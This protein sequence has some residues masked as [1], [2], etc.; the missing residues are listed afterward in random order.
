[1]K[2]AF[3]FLLFL[4]LLGTH[5]TKAQDNEIGI[6]GGVANYKGDLA[7]TIQFNEFRPAAG[8]FYKKN[9][10]RFFSMGAYLTHGSV[11]GSD[12]NV[13]TRR[14]RNLS[15]ESDITELSFIVEFNFLPFVKGR[16]PYRFTPNVFLGVGGFYFNPTTTLDGETFELNE[17]RTE[18][19][20]I[21]NNDDGAYS[22]F[23]VAIP[24]GLGLK[25]DLAP[26]WN[27]GLQAGYRYT[28]TDYLD[29]VGGQ[30]ANSGLL[31][32]E[33]APE[34]ATLADRSASAYGIEG[35]NRGDN[36]YNDWYFFAGFTLSY[37]IKNDVCY[38]R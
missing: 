29:D 7:P 5:Q 28:F 16:D 26:R 30:F 12:Q 25:Y 36:Q 21:G 11:G 24:M 27:L 32:E 17:M 1:M 33:V 15:F 34:S 13:E 31:S 23:Q 37:K 9:L 14:E 20:G 4:G 19:Q 2:Y 6:M 22:L 35:R 3:C 38:Y 8:V 18:G 10:S